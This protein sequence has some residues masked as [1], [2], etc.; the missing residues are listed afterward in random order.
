MWFLLQAR[1]ENCTWIHL[2]KVQF[3]AVMLPKRFTGRRRT[4]NSSFEHEHGEPCQRH[5]SL[6]L[7]WK[8][9]RVPVLSCSLSQSTV[10][11][12]V[13]TLTQVRRHIRKVS[14]WTLLSARLFEARFLLDRITLESRTLS[15]FLMFLVAVACV[16]TD[17]PRVFGPVSTCWS[18]PHPMCSSHMVPQSLDR[19]WCLFILRHMITHETRTSDGS[20]S[21]P[22]QKLC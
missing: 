17:C 15:S 14:V 4:D 22:L 11:V 18:R 1:S 6:T 19:V 12:K 13:V 8:K 3:V 20:A 7:R 21:D 2:G 16:S 10:N 5:G 9:E